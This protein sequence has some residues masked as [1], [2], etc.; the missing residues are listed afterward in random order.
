MEVRI[1][2]DVDDMQNANPFYAL[3]L[4]LRRGRR[5]EKGTIHK[6]PEF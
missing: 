5:F 3:G 6:S 2:M 4:G 1:C